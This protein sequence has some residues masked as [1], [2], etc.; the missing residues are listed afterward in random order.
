M[1]EKIAFWAF[2]AI[3]LAASYS[4][5]MQF[6]PGTWRGE[7]PAGLDFGE[8]L[9]AVYQDLGWDYYVYRFG[10]FG[11]DRTI[12]N[13]DVI[14]SSSSKGLYGF[15]PETLSRQLSTGDR[16]IKVF[17][18]SFGFGEGFG[19]LIEVIKTLDLRDKILIADL[20]DNTATYH[21]TPMAKLALQTDNRGDAYKVMTER[22]LAFERDW[23]L[24]SHVPRIHFDPIKGFVAESAV[25]YLLLRSWQTGRLQDVSSPRSLLHPAPAQYSFGFDGDGRLRRLFLEECANRNIQVIFTSIP[26]QGYDE[27]WGQRIAREL[28]YPHVAV[29]PEGITLIE[30]THMSV[31]GRLLFSSR[32]GARLKE[33][34]CFDAAMSLARR[35]SGPSR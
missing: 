26:Y 15:D 23:A 34:G 17:N 1:R 18:L 8:L 13:A 16:Q 14:C 3:S 31:S 10:L 29:D 22:W 11:H 27:A 4:L 32:L 9:P 30:P 35:T 24:H 21:L 2:F 7:K 12:Q 33:T 20:T 25:G 5:G 19:Y 28:G 6:I